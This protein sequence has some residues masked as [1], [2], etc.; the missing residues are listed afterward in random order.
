MMTSNSSTPTKGRTGRVVFTY[1]CAKLPSPMLASIRPIV[2]ENCS[3]L[4]PST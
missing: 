2:M 3:T 4:L 1:C